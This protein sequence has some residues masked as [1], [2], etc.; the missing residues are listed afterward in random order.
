MSSFVPCGAAQACYVVCAV[1]VQF[2]PDI[3]ENR[4]GVFGL[5]EEAEKEKQPYL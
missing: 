3:Q 2:V 4:I 1:Y 5:R